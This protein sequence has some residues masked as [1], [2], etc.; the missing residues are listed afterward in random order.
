M[1]LFSHWVL[2]H[3]NHYMR[4]SATHSLSYCQ[5]CSL[6][7]SLSHSMSCRWTYECVPELCPGC[8][9]I[10]LFTRTYRTWR[11]WGQTHE[12]ARRHHGGPMARAKV[13]T[14]VA[15]FLY[16]NVLAHYAVQGPRLFYEPCGF[17]RDVFTPPGKGSGKDTV[18]LTELC[19]RPQPGD[20]P[21]RVTS[22]RQ[23]K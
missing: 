23:D 1:I 10:L 4:P 12:S 19:R 15:M 6:S 11:A 9:R 16:E 7:C 20:Y 14:L 18:V 2:H 22:A 17:W 8:V 3:F 5:N 21:P 13:F